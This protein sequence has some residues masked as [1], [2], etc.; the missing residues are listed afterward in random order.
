MGYD[1][2]IVGGT[3]V[4]L[5]A[6]IP[7]DD[8]L[9][10]TSW[11]PAHGDVN[12]EDETAARDTYPPGA[13]TGGNVYWMGKVDNPG[14]WN[15][16]VSLR[17]EPE[18][19]ATGYGIFPNP[20]D[21]NKFQ[22]GASITYQENYNHWMANKQGE[23]VY[24]ENGAYPDAHEDYSVVKSAPRE[25]T[26]KIP[27]YTKARVMVS[28][29]GYTGNNPYAAYR[30]EAKI[31]LTATFAEK[32]GNGNPIKKVADINVEQSRRVMNPKAIWREANSTEP[33]HAVLKILPYQA[34][35]KFENLYSYGPWRAE[36][37][38]GKGW[39]TLKKGSGNSQ[40]NANGSITGTGDLYS[41]DN[42]D[43]RRIDFNI[44]FT[45]GSGRGGLITVYYNNYTCVHTIF[46]R[47]G[48]DP[49]E[50]KS[51]PGVMW[52]TY[53]LRTGGVNTAENGIAQEA[54]APEV[55]GSYFRFRNRQFPIDPRSNTVAKAFK[56]GISE[57]FLI[58][59]PDG[60]TETKKWDDIKSSATSWGT[61]KVKIN[62]VDTESRLPTE[63]EWK[64][65]TQSTDALFGYG[66]IYTDNATETLE[67][68][69]EVYG[70][71]PGDHESGKGM[72]GVIICDG[73]DGTQIFLPLA[74]S[75]YGRF[76]QRSN[77]DV[78]NR[79]PANWG[80]V[81]QYAN[82]YSWFPD[83]G[84]FDVTYKPLFYD[85]W[86]G[87]GTM[88]WAAGDAFETSYALDINYNTLDMTVS[89]SDFN[90]LGLI[91]NGGSYYADPSGSDAVHIRLV[92]DKK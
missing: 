36:V 28:Q 43:G 2:K 10:K 72:R 67:N 40:E 47:Q 62:E 16:F 54:I 59:L 19:D 41:D 18:A 39:I 29:T 56:N 32:D 14:P 60:A 27:L 70:A 37:T 65:I 35:P 50:F 30:R 26:C 83:N 9:N 44:N 71:H 6:S 69:S 51:C 23:R 17:A 57:N 42:M 38:L 92:H 77:S 87:E 79:L 21:N 74:A 85:L 24:W 66:V 86:E 15:G 7:E 73:S 76:K 49:V 22:S 11:A 12:P 48:Y 78:Y 5:E 4:K 75:G 1:L 31:R 63:Q 25:Y 64:N 84:G 88:Y 33:F 90:S 52:H 20:A 81:I 8:D 3:L 55:E 34:S 80:G 46:V 82:R 91:W 13:T 89:R 68:I 45:A 53:N 58:A 61:F